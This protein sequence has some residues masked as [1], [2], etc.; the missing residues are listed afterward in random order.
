[1]FNS[2]P[3]NMFPSIKTKLAAKKQMENILSEDRQKEALQIQH[4]TQFQCRLE[5]KDL[6][7]QI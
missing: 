3:L 7:D 5:S 2:S 1:M 6:G 4:I